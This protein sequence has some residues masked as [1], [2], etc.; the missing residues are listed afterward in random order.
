MLDVIYSSE[1][2]DQAAGDA[3]IAQAIDA[4]GGNVVLGSEALLSPRE[5]GGVAVAKTLTPYAKGLVEPFSN[6][7]LQHALTPAH[8]QV[9][10]DTT[11]G[12]N[13]TIPMVVEAPDGQFVPRSRSPR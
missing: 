1:R 5:D 3:A 12:V 4:G 8:V 7:S 10:A 9:T 2:E 13:R 11:D 6:G